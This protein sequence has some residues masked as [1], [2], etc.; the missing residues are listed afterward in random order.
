MGSKTNCDLWADDLVCDFFLQ[1]T[2]TGTADGDV[3]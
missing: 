3:A 1:Y 2:G